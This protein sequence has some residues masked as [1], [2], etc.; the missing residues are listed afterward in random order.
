MIDQQRLGF[1][2][3]IL[4]G[5]ILL[6]F[7]TVPVYVLPS[8][9]FQLVDIP[10]IFGMV[11]ASLVLNRELYDR[12]RL[13]VML[14]AVY[15]SWTVL[16]NIVYFVGRSDLFYMKSAIQLVFIV[17]MFA[18][19]VVL[20]QRL[21]LKKK[22]VLCIYAGLFLSLIPPFLVTGSYDT[23]DTEGVGGVSMRTALSFNNPNQLA[24]FAILI[25]AIFFLI[26]LYSRRFEFTRWQRIG[27]GFVAVA[28]WVMS[29]AFVFLSASRAGL[30]CIGVLD[31]LIFWKLRRKVVIA[32]TLLIVLLLPA[33]V[34]FRN[35]LPQVDILVVQRLMMTD[36]EA[37]MSK[38][39]GTRFFQSLASEYAA[40]FGSGG[41][42][43]N[44]KVIEVHNAFADMLLCYG[45]IG[46]AIYLFFLSAVAVPYLRF[47]RRYED[48]YYLGILFAIMLYNVGHNGMRTRLYWVFLA[49]WFAVTREVIRE[50]SQE[51][52]SPS[53]AERLVAADAPV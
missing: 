2:E 51:I 27:T 5:I 24:Y 30:I 40:M 15:V 29:H 49:L 44:P 31:C 39:V 46:V 26:R 8:G 21:I 34:I 52:E 22:G 6:F 13:I 42:S 48:L 17:F 28:V 37:A 18:A 10:I 3:K 36:T 9:G 33:G 1:S 41:V 4:H 25:L 45:M 12:S 23:T 32:G 47:M 35:D 50:R 14:L 20:L 38:R 11:L 53:R 43:S 7:L 19:F 16:I